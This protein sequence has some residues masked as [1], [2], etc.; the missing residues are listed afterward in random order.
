[1][2]NVI[3]LF[4]ENIIDTIVISM[5][6]IIALALALPA[7]I[8]LPIK[9]IRIWFGGQIKRIGDTMTY[10]VKKDMVDDNK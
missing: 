7:L 6:C 2:I 8:F 3:R 1:M 9:R 4:F 5:L 10:F